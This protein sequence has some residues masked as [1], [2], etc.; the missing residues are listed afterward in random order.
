MMGKEVEMNIIEPFDGEQ[1]LATDDCGD[2]AGRCCV[3]ERERKKQ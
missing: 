3:C 1:Y 2:Y